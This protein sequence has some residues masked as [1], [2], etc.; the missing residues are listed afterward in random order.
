[1]TRRSRRIALAIAV[2]PLVVLVGLRSAWAAYACRVDRQVR[3][4]C[5]CGAKK[6]SSQHRPADDGPRLQASSCCDVMHGESAP[7]PDART[8]EA[9][10]TDFVPCLIA[11][12]PVAPEPAVRTSRGEFEH[13]AR[14]PP[15]DVP[16][17]LANRSILL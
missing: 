6:S 7:P 10:Q 14:P 13:S 16:I 3:S 15:P 5:C 1:V 9:H 12:V 8:T 2:L 4:E 17:Y 11:S